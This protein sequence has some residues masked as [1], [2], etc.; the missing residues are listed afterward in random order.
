[1]LL[2][3]DFLEFAVPFIEFENLLYFLGLES[4]S[5]EYGNRCFFNYN[6]SVYYAGIKIGYNGCKGYQCYVQFSGAGC[7][8][9]ESIHKDHDFDWL[10]FIK[11]LFELNV[12]FRRLDIACDDYTDN[13]DVYKLARYYEKNMIAGACRTF[14]YILG[15]EHVFYAGSSK[16]DCLLRIYNKALER[17]YSFEDLGHPWYRCEIQTRKDN[18]KQFISEWI[19]FDSLQK[20]F[21]GHVLDWVRFL[22]KPND[23]S[24]SQR[25]ATAAFWRRFLQ[26]AERIKFVSKPGV[27]Y[28]L[29]K[30]DR[31]IDNQAASSIK[32]FIKSHGFS[33]DEVYNLFTR[34]SISLRTD[35]EVVLRDA[36]NILSRLRLFD[37]S[38]LEID[39]RG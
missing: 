9:F 16:S 3:V 1:M 12:D 31:F 28:N 24:N 32:L 21:C 23:K 20:V 14:R 4:I 36:E 26:N 7:R 19:R 17:G 5:F 10:F 33:P 34:D 38:G 6:D 2:T 30:C 8:S 39:E 37:A 35:Q 18:C 25:I 29:R 13:L 11:S 27:E 22:N 15:S